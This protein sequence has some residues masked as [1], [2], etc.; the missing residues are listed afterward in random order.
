MHI[1]LRSSCLPVPALIHLCIALQG[2]Q[3]LQKGRVEVASQT[4]VYLYCC[5]LIVK[6]LY[7]LESA[8]S[9]PAH[10]V[11]ELAWLADSGL[12]THLPGIMG[13]VVDGTLPPWLATNV[14]QALVPAILDLVVCLKVALGLWRRA[15][16]GA[17]GLPSEAEG[18]SASLPA[19]AL[20]LGLLDAGVDVWAALQLAVALLYSVTAW[21]QAQNMQMMPASAAH[22]LVL[23]LPHLPLLVPPGML[24]TAALGVAVMLQEVR[25]SSPS[26]SQWVYVTKVATLGQKAI[27]YDSRK[28][29]SWVG[30]ARALAE[31]ASEAADIYK[32]ITAAIGKEAADGER[33]V[34]VQTSH[35]YTQSECSAR[36]AL[37]CN[38]LRCTY[39]HQSELLLK[40]SLVTLHCKL[41]NC[42]D[43]CTSE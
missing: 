8:P 10:A 24:S 13:G 19:K 21:S 40:I 34:S 43:V 1:L 36:C 31:L 25:R 30:D 28:G 14:S 18:S 3:I 37:D 35:L 42:V 33:W 16:A 2:L 41:L 22:A 39:L 32:A 6:H 38:T 12:G 11:N 17:N 29:A 4:W 5:T 15:E 9:S 7:L 20:H 27:G 23:K 26:P